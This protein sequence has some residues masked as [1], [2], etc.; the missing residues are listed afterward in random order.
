MSKYRNNGIT[1]NT[2]KRISLN[3]GTLHFGLEY[4]NGEWNFEES[5]VC[6]TQGGSKFTYTEN[7]EQIEVDNAMVAVEG[8]DVKFGDSGK[9]ETNPIEITEDLLE[10][11]LHLIQAETDITGYKMYNTQ[12]SLPKGAYIH[13]IGLV[14]ETSNQPIIIIMDL[15]IITS[16][17]EL[18]TKSKQGNA[19]KLTIEARAPLS[20]LQYNNCP[21]RIY[22]PEIYEEES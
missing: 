14:S 1:Q 3:A 8:L 20:Q 12:M 18:D 6:A 13:N 4:K 21:I 7:I 19:Y 22:Y 11:A 5:L 9:L 2:P 15:G 16:G 17:F 10:K